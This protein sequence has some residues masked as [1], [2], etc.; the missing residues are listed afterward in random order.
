MHELRILLFGQVEIVTTGGTPARPDTVRVAALL[1]YLA[2][3]HDTPHRREKLAELL[4]PDQ[5]PGRGRRLLSDALWRARRL[6]EAAGEPSALA[7]GRDTVVLRLAPGVH[8]DA[9]AFERVA[10]A[11]EAAAVEDLEAAIKL[12][13]GDFIEECYDD[14]AIPIRERLHEQLLTLLGQ[15]L[16]RRRERGEHEAALQVALRLLEYDPLREETHREI[17]RLYYLLGREADALRAYERCRELLARELGVAPEP[18]TTAL[19]EEI[20]ALSGGPVAAPEALIGDVR[21]VGRRLERAALLAAV[22]RALA[23]EGGVAVVAGEAGQGKTRLLREL[24]S[25]A[26]WRGAHVHWGR[27]FADAR[28]RPLGP[29]REALESLLARPAARQALTTLERGLVDELA[30][31]L[32]DLADGTPRRPGAGRPSRLHVAVAE[33]LLALSAETGQVLIFEDVHAFD[34]A[35]VQALAGILPR[36]HGAAVLVVLS[37][38]ADELP[39]HAEV[40]ELL[41][42]LDRDGLLLRVE[43]DGMGREECLELVRHA[44]RQGQAPETLGDQIYHVTGGNPFFVLETLRS[45]RERRL[46]VLADDGRWSL[47]GDGNLAVQLPSDLRRLIESRL[48]GLSP[49]EQRALAAASVL[50]GSFS[51]ALWSRMSAADSRSSEAHNAADVPGELLRRRFL[52]KGAE[53]YQFNHGLLQEVVYQELADDE[54]RDLHLQ[55]AEALEQEHYARIEALAQ[56]LCLAGAWARAL[57]YLVQVGDRARQLCAYGDALHAYDQALTAVA[58]GGAA[59]RDL[60]WSLLLK[61]AEICTLLGDYEAALLAYESARDTAAGA[62]TEGRGVQV[63]SLS[64]ICYVHGLRND[65]ERA[66]TAVHVALELARRGVAASDRAD[67]FYHAGLI[68]YRTDHYEAAEAL[69]RDASELYE[70]LETPDAPARQ[71]RCLETLAGCWSRLEGA[72]ERVIAAQERA[73]SSWRSLG[74][75]H[76]EHECLLSLSNMYLLRGDLR[77]AL[78]S[79]DAVQPFFRAARTFEH[80]AQSQYLRGEALARMGQVEEGL[81][82]LDEALGLCRN[83][84]RA[85][86]AQFVQIYVGRALC[87]L[88]RFDEAEVALRE[89]AASEDRLIRARALGAWAE[90][91]LERS[92]PGAAFEAAAESLGLLRLVGVRPLLGRGLRVLGQVRAAGGAALPPPDD[93]LPAAEPCFRAGIALLE[94]ARYEGDVGEALA[95]Y[96]EW[97]LAQGRTTEAYETLTRARQ[98]FVTCAMQRAVE[99]VDRVIL[100]VNSAASASTVVYVTLPRRAAPRG[101]PLEPHE[102]VRVRWTLAQGDLGEGA[103][104]AGRRRDLLRQ[105]C[106]EA[107]AQNAEP[108]I[109]DLAA[110]LGVAPRTISRDLAAMRAAGEPLPAR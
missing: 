93:A 4:W 103:L 99:R 83:L 51:G 97:L 13:R 100:T 58:Q 3:H 41:L 35:T 109:N 62:G 16:A 45:L 39:R 88:G 89:A 49:D 36:I 69:L 74:D 24:A 94:E 61:R 48:H 38:R 1:G 23:A 96:G 77:R 53:E 68:E 72:S 25:G 28:R 29:L 50:G 63:R 80:V 22:E 11:G 34:V 40:W 92:D 55:A 76:G 110:V 15:L 104:A 54:R 75:R 91:H 37:G 84:G 59:P 17:I 43:L 65:Y 7:T 47:A 26:S 21:F 98:C 67:A 46:L 90:L 12:Y 18:A 56:H 108:T 101:R 79:G 57:P 70:T 42:G 66:R 105:L 33:L 52:V 8:V 106:M 20:A 32:P 71:A 107:V 31:L 9:V 44:L 102:L 87:A 95:C 78:S 82:A 10:L 30:L 6:L 64:G 81:A 2:V 19:Y 27:G 60:Q 5:E 85:A 14:W 73:L 86:A